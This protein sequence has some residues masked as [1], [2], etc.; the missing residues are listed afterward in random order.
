VLTNL[1]SNAVK[2]GFAHS[3]IDVELARR[4]GQLEVTITNEGEGIPEDELPRL[5]RRFHR[6]ETAR[7]S[8]IGGLGLGLYI[9][10]GLIEAHG[11]RIWA[12]STP[13]K[14]TSFHFTL[15]LPEEAPEQPT[16]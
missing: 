7:Q 15:P 14:K 13:G 16:A 5:F 1:L 12:E 3:R 2:Y 10:R 11:G 6:T 4:G 9:T 8:R